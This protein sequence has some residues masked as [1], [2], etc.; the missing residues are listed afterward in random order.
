MFSLVW[1]RWH[2]SGLLLYAGNPDLTNLTCFH[3]RSRVINVA[4]DIGMQYFLVG[5]ALL[6]DRSGAVVPQIAAELLGN[7]ERIN[8][9]ILR[10]WIQG[11]GV[12]DRSWGGLL[13]VLRESG[14]AALAEEMEEALA[15]PTLR[16]LRQ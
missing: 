12:E 8:M 7:A 15:T 10:R 5:T 2:K 1:R 16:G 13:R 9:E 11:S 14:R 6:N 3:G 4:V